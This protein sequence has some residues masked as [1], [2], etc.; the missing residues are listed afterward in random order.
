MDLVL[1]FRFLGL[2]KVP[3]FGRNLSLV[4]RSLTRGGPGSRSIVFL[5]SC[6]LLKSR[7]QQ[8]CYATAVTYAAKVVCVFFPGVSG[9]SRGAA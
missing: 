4:N 5:H 7:I 8:M 3:G 2:E 1:V 6:C 9:V